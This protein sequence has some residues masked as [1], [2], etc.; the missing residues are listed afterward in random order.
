M[1][2]YLA[3]KQDDKY[4]LERRKEGF[5][6]SKFTVV[7]TPTITEGGIASGFSNANYVTINKPINSDNNTFKFKF[8]YNGIKPEIGSFYYLSLSSGEGEFFYVYQNSS[9]ALSIY[10]TKTG[11]TS[12]WAT[13][14]IVLYASHIGT[15]FDIEVVTTSEKYTCNV[16]RDSVLLGSQSI[17]TTNLLPSNISIVN[18]GGP[19]NSSTLNDNSIDLSSFSITVDGKEVFTGAKE[20]FYMLQKP[21]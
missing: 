8:K 10:S 9:N 5:D 18:L 17:A 6:L 1:N 12:I 13:P 15:T 16:Y 2:K 21:N 14:I 7:G 20:H 3:L 19:Q 4:L 11:A